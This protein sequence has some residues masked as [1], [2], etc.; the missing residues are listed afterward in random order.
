MVLANVPP[1]D[2]F[3]NTEVVNQL[4]VLKVLKDLA[5]GVLFYFVTTRII[6]FFGLGEDYLFKPSKGVA[7]I[8]KEG[9]RDVPYLL[10]GHD[11][12]HNV[13]ALRLGR[14]GNSGKEDEK[15]RSRWYVNSE[16]WLPLFAKERKRLLR[17]PLEYTFVRMSDTHRVLAATDENYMQPS[18]HH[19]P[20]VQLLRWNDPASVVELAETFAGKEEIAGTSAGNGR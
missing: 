7:K 19:R 2:R 9:G 3:L 18:T 8:L 6:K 15:E 1:F 17:K 14:R 4:V 13:Q 12:A 11:H 20:K 5:I 10:F 16:S